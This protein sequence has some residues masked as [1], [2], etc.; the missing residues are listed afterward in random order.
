MPQEM[1]EVMIFATVLAPVVLALVQLFKQ[2]NVPKTLVPLIAVMIGIAIGIVAQPFTDMNLTLRIWAGGLAGL[3]STGLFE[4]IKT[5]NGY[6]K[7]E[8]E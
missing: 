7:G 3:S 4:L 1:L 2:I 6:T 8:E 5:N